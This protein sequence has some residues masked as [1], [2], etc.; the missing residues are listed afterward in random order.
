[1][2]G[3]LVAA[4][5]FGRA[6]SPHAQ[7]Q[8]FRGG[9]A[10]VPVYASVADGAGGFV[11]D[12]TRDEFEIRDNG[13]IQQIAQ[14]TRGLQPLTSVVLLDGSGSMLPEFRVVIEAADHF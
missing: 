5:L 8:P 3:A 14:F 12:L 7:Q 6:P 1:M 10:L 4:A 13:K 2:A 9:T 11:L